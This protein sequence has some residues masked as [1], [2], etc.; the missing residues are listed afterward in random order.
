MRCNLFHRQKDLESRGQATLRDGLARAWWYLLEE[1][2]GKA[3]S[4]VT[5]CIPTWRYHEALH[6][7]GLGSLS[8]S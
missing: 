5:I 8:R 3:I 7:S 6:Q 2:D 4:H 1:K